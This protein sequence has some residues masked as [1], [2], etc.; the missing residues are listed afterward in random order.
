ME[1]IALAMQAQAPISLGGVICDLPTTYHELF[2]L[3]NFQDTI[4]SGHC[5]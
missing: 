3:L 4:L 5:P 2:F 1:G